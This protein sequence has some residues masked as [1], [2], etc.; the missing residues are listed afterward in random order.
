[1]SQVHKTGRAVKDD[2]YEQFARIGKAVANSKRIELLDLLCQGERSVEALAEAAAM[3]VTNTS[4]HLRVLREARLVE[5]RKAGTWVFYRL[6]DE[7]VCDFFLSLRDLASNRFAEVERV[8][9]DY[10]EGRDQ[11]DPVGTAELL[12]RAGDGDVI[13]LDVRPGEEY[14]AGHIAGAISVPL[15]ELEER[16]ASLP[17]D[18][19]IVAYCRGRYCVLAPQALELLHSHGFRARRLVDGLPEWRQA[20]LPIA[21]G[22]ESR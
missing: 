1:M 12:A 9:R 21:V 11:L 10:F 2:L 22:K 19:E 15:G 7:T 5:T 16:L 13:V 4:A 17:K 20:G 6:A 18:S 8:M 3:G 14:E